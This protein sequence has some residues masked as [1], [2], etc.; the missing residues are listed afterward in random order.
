MPPIPKPKTTRRNRPNGL[1]AGL[2]FAA[3][4]GGLLGLLLLFEAPRVAVREKA[5]D[6]AKAATSARMVYVETEP[7]GAAVS[8]GGVDSGYMALKF[9]IGLPGRKNAK[10]LEA[11]L[12][13][14]YGQMV[15]DFSRAPIR[16]DDESGKLDL[17]AIEGRVRGL[18]DDLL[19]PG[20]VDTVRIVDVRRQ[21]I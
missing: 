6:L 10:Q 12:P 15:R 20:I 19:G 17:L 13:L 16:P 14:L 2:G 3:L 11:V 9:R 7:M 18:L 5:E 21:V 4:I 8:T 1:L